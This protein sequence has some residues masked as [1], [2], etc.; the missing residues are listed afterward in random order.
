MNYA[1]IEND[2]VTNIIVLLPGNASDFP[3]TAPVGDKPVGIGDE[4]RD[5][6]FY[7]NG[8]EILS[9]LEIAQTENADLLNLLG[10]AAELEYQNAMEVI[11]NV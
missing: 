11:E 9:P 7:R 1:L 4:Y 10:E 3:D 8:K 5:G 6:K 2:I